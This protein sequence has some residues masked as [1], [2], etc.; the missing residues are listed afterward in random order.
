MIME[1]NL[2]KTLDQ[3]RHVLLSVAKFKAYIDTFI[4]YVLDVLALSS[5]ILH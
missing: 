4:C 3:K 5:F 1:M 2:N